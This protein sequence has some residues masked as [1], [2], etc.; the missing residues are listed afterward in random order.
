MG[1]RRR[2]TPPYDSASLLGNDSRPG[3]LRTPPAA[4]AA[5]S[6]FHKCP[7][8]SLPW[9]LLQ[10]MTHTYF[11]ECPRGSDCPGLPGTTIDSTYT[12]PLL[13]AMGWALGVC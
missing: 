2:G 3:P 4:G 7:L 9:Q 1:G 12:L 10:S 5:G 6:S 13:V 11:W 8:Q